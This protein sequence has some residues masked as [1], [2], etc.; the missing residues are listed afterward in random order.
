MKSA[1]GPL[2]MAW[3]LLSPAPWAFALW[4]EGVSGPVRLVTGE[5]AKPPVCRG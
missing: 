4:N 5:D 1:T 2:H 3:A